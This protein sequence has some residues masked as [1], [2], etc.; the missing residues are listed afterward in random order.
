M[1]HIVGEKNWPG[2]NQYGSA[3]A[4]SGYEGHWILSLI[5]LPWVKIIAAYQRLSPQS[6]NMGCKVLLD[7]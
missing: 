4:I 7:G 1:L 3:A 5:N 6:I 2:V